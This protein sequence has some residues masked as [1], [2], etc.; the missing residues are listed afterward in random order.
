MQISIAMCTYNGEKYLR[1]QLESI[2]RQTTLP[3]ELVVCDDVS[4]DSTP[5]IL[6]EF[7]KAAPFPVRLIRNRKNLGST[8]NFEQA[9]GLCTC[10]LIALSDQDDIWMPEKLA[11]QSELLERNPELGGVFSDAQLVDDRSALLGQ[12][13][14]ASILFT[15]PDQERF[16]AGRAA[17]VLIRRNVVTGATLIFRANLRPLFSPIPAAWVH[18]GW[19]T[20]MLV[21]YSK[22]AFIEDPLIHYRLHPDQQIGVEALTL[23]RSLSL[24]KR[25]KKGRR[26]GAGKNLAHLR[27][28]EVL[29]QR[30]AASPG[31]E[32]QVVLPALR[33]K[34]NFFIDRA[35]P[36][37][38][39]LFLM[40]RILRNAGNYDRYENGWKSLLRDI[41]IAFI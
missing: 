27:E 34:I 13:L 4:T 25:L 41:A 6:A 37:P 10:D 28:L 15:Q 35:R 23:S 24:R 26:E 12:N 9:I 29:E 11:R 3:S 32:T 2:A 16:K 5:E 36:Y 20:W 38:N 30:L 22:L 18:D 17:T 40:C 21:M 33:Q 14:W 39:R 31:A 8:K 1:D 19:I 7:T